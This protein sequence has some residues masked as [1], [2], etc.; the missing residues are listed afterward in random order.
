M[1]DTDTTTTDATIISI[2]A[3]VLLGLMATSAGR[4]AFESLDLD[5]DVREQVLAAY[6]AAAAERARD[7]AAAMLLTEYGVA[8]AQ[9]LSAVGEE[10]A[11]I[12]YTIGEL[13]RSARNPKWVLSKNNRFHDIPTT[14][15]MLRVSVAPITGD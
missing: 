14:R 3:K 7:D 12:V 2:D 5:P 9:Q 8:T 10:L 6:A 13:S 1:T 15:G 4:S 11:D